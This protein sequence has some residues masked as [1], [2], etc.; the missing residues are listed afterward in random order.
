MHLSFDEAIGSK[1]EQGGEE[2]ELCYSHVLTLLP[3]LLSH[4]TPQW[5]LGKIWDLIFCVKN[6]F[7]VL[8]TV[9]DKRVQIENPGTPSGEIKLWKRLYRKDNNSL[10]RKV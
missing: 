2:I 7:S 5:V 9:R 6:Q 10:E 1:D 8:N 4:R 3:C